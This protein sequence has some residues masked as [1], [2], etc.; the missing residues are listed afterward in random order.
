MSFPGFTASDFK[1]FDIPGFKARMEAIRGRIR[2]KLEAAGRD[3]LPDVTRIGG[4]QAFRGQQA[5]RFLL[6]QG[7]AKPARNHG[8]DESFHAPTQQRRL[9]GLVHYLVQRAR[10]GEPGERPHQVGEGAHI[11]LWLQEVRRT[12]GLAKP[13][14][15][16]DERP[17][18]A[19]Q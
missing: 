9:P 2:P 11:E 18:Q 8:H 13:H 6:G 17:E 7:A 1:V 4:A 3:L 10:E 16:A 5:A 14:Q 15:P 12:L 19:N